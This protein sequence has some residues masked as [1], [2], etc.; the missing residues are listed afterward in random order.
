MGVER[1]DDQLV[2]RLTA[3]AGSHDVGRVVLS[4][5]SW[6]PERR[7]FWSI[8]ANQA[9]CSFRSRQYCG[10][11]R[12]GKYAHLRSVFAHCS[13]F[14]ERIGNASTAFGEGWDRRQS[15]HR[16]PDGSVRGRR[17]DA[18]GAHSRAARESR[19]TL[20]RRSRITNRELPMRADSIASPGVSS[21]FAI[22]HSLFAVRELP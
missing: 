8:L 17:K 7:G 12:A 2:P 10:G 22:R 1:F 19:D 14:V 6:L 18:P 5:D 13:R 11:A 4:A 20:M 9:G 3:V 16:C 21:L 15:A